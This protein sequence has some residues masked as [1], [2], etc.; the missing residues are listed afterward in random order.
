MSRKKWVRVL[1]ANITNNPEMV[2]NYVI[3]GLV[4][5]LDFI[6]RVV[7]GIDI[8]DA[9]ADMALLA[10]TTFISILVDN[11]KQNQTRTAPLVPQHVEYD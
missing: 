2:K 7:L 11:D 8:V 10:V 3:P 1:L 5:L 4:F 6:L 9:G